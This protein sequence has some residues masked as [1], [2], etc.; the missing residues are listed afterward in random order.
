MII[1]ANSV[2]PIKST[3]QIKIGDI[4]MTSIGYAKVFCLNPIKTVSI[5]RGTM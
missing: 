4:I 3:S 5:T 2:N 1:N